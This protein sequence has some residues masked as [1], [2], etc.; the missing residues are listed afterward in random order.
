MNMAVFMD[1]SLEEMLRNGQLPRLI[2]Y[3]ESYSAQF[4]KVYVVT[5]DKKNM[6]RCLPDGCFHLYTGNLPAGRLIHPFLAPLLFRRELGESHI[7]RVLGLFLQSMIPS[8]IASLLYTKPV[9]ATYQYRYSE[10]AKTEGKS[11]LITL[12]TRLKEK[13]GLLLATRVIV[14]TKDLEEHVRSEVPEKEIWLIPNGVILDFFSETRKRRPRKGSN[15][16][17]LFVGRLT[18]QKNLFSLLEAIQSMDRLTLTIVGEGPLHKELID[19]S[20]EL[21]LDVRFEGYVSHDRLREYYYDADVFVIPSLIE[22][23]PKVLLEAMACRL[24]VVGTNVEGTNEIIT[25]EY[26]GLLC[27]TNPESIGNAVKRLLEDREYAEKLGENARDLIA[28]EYDL[29]SLLARETNLM[30]DLALRDK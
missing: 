24:P 3:L 2:F 5:H 29:T 17:I 10:F 26:N 4:E 25:H 8:M 30:M 22:G 9:V 11:P 7:Y 19:Y 27:D 14:T 1:T 6:Q 20:K 18:K 12:L 16:N 21:G 15:R 23:H 28:Q 13:V